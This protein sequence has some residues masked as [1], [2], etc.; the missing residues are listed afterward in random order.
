[1]RIVSTGA[2]SKIDRDEAVRARFSPGVLVVIPALNEAGGLPDVLAQV[3]S[4][5]PRADVLVIDDGSSDDTAAQAHR[6]GAFVA[7]HP[8]NLG[9]GAALQTG[10]KFALERGYDFAVQMDADGQHDPHGLESILKPVQS[11]STDIVIGSRYLEKGGYRSSL[12][13]RVGSWLLGHIASLFTG[14]RVT[15]FPYHGTG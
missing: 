11:G 3:H 14:K 7:R 5:L 4:A 9:Y 13:R 2:V 6:N 8:F 15:S 10:Y 1:M 12:K